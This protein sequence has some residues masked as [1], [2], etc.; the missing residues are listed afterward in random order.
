MEASGGVHVPA[1]VMRHWDLVQAFEGQMYE[2]R[3][4]LHAPMR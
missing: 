3:T 4:R 1:N 2:I